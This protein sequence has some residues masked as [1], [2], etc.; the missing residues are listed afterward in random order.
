MGFTTNTFLFLFLPAVLAVYFLCHAIVKKEKIGNVIL[1]LF[2]MVFYAWATEIHAVLLLIYALIIYVFG[3]LI[4]AK[5]SK[6]KYIL[7]PGLIFTIGLL[8]YYKY[9]PVIAGNIQGY[10]QLPSNPFVN[11][12]APLGISFIT[13]S[14]ITYLVDIYRKDTM[15]DSLLD[16][17]LFFFFFPKVVSG[18]IIPWK[19][20]QE[21]LT[22]RSITSKKL[23][24]GCNRIAIGFAKKVIIA[25]TLGSYASSIASKQIDVPSAWFGWIL[26]AMQL[27]YDFSGYSDIAIGLAN[28]FGFDFKENFNFP[29]LSTSVTEFWRRWHISLGSF[30]RNY[31]YIPLGG[32]RKG[33]KRTLINL[34]IVFVV[35]GMWHGAG[36]AY[37]A[38]GCIHGFCVIFE[39]IVRNKSWYQKIPSVIKWAITFFIC[40]SAWE[41]FR[42]GVFSATF[43]EY[44]KMLGIFSYEREKWP[45]YS[46]IDKKC[47]FY[48]IIAIIGAL[49][50][51]TKKVLSFYESLKDKYW[52]YILQE[53]VIMVLFILSIIYMMSSTFTP[54]IYF[55]F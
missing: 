3:Q 45:W 24:Y 40:V 38:W 30:F 49:L 52:F 6:K 33:Y 7:I 14:A 5:E 18:P 46:Y 2:S 26:Y 25:D 11:I 8:V 55:Q 29:Y 43:V 12:T 10:L 27:Y 44:G 37:V 9:L 23:V 21:Q 19:D 53:V 4:K 28:L 35:T 41:F 36:L 54:F 50:P 31:L 22:N 15:N 32:N 48:L 51:G 13:F 1:L 42:Y 47:I 20:F 39:R 16:C 17:L 34:G